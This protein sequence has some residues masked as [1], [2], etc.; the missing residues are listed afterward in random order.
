MPAVIRSIRFRLR[1][2]RIV[3]PFRVVRPHVGAIADPKQ[4]G[5]VWP[6]GVFMH[7][8]GRMHDE[9]ARHDVDCLERRAHFAPALETEIDFRGVGMAM[10]GADLPGFPAGHRHIASADALENLFD[11]MVGVPFLLPR[12]IENMH[13]GAP[14]SWSELRVM[15][16]LVP[17]MTAETVCL[18]SIGK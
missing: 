17:A 16:G 9:C 14:V 5:T 7:L 8:T 2:G 3:S 18:K 4:H 15:A 6:I 1:P 10:I 12:Q 13:D 11:M